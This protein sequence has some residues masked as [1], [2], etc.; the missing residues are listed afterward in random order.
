MDNTVKNRKASWREAQL[1]AIT[2][3]RLSP[4]AARPALLSL[5]CLGGSVWRKGRAAHNK[6]PIADSAV[7]SHLHR[8]A[9]CL[10]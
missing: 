5:R 8:I 7:I 9:I 6:L 2:P 4:L 1:L 3:L 10:C